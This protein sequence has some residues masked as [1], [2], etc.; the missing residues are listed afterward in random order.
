MTALAITPVHAILPTIAAGAF[1]T[2]PAGEENAVALRLTNYSGAAVTVSLWLVPA[3]EVLASK[4]YRLA[5]WK[6]APATSED[7][8][9]ALPLPPGASL[10]ATAS[11][12]NSVAASL[13]GTRR[14][15][16]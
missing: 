12:A 14:S 3:G 6:L 2:V 5:G 16:A 7:P 10:Y 8:E 1:F 15:L 9:I 4:H 13:T 11:V